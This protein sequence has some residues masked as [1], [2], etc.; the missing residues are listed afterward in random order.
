LCVDPIKN[1]FRLFEKW[2]VLECHMQENIKVFYL[3]EDCD[4]DTA[5][6]NVYDTIAA[7]KWI[8]NMD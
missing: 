3:K 5:T 8:R 2:N 7:F 6:K 1:S 4:T